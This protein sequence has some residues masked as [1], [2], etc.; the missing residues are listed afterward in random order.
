MSTST[1]HTKPGMTGESITQLHQR[2]VLLGFE[3][4]ADELEEDRYGPGTEAAVRQFQ[5][6]NGLATVDGRVDAATARGLGL[7]ACPTSIEGIVSRPDGTPLSDVAVRLYQPSA[8]GEKVLAQ[9]RSGIDGKFAMPWP[10]GIRGGLNVRADGSAERSVSWKTTLASDA[11]WVRLSVGG[12]YRGPTRFAVLTQML[13]PAA[14]AGEVHLL[15]GSGRA[16]DLAAIGEAV[17]VPAP[18]VSR[19]VLSHKLAARTDLDPRVCFALLAHSVT[20]EAL[21]S[22]ARSTGD[23]EALDD[24]YV[25][26]L[27]DVVLWQHRDELRAGLAAAVSQNLVEDVDVEAA[28]AQL[29]ELRI[30]HL[31][32]KPLTWSAPRITS[33]EHTCCEVAD[34][35]VQASEASEATAG[36]LHASRPLH[37]HDAPLGDV[38]AAAL[39]EPAAR[40]QALEAFAAHGNHARLDAV[41]DSAAGLT[42]AQR[43]DLRFTLEVAALLG[44]HL[45]LVKHAQQLRAGK[46]IAG[47]ADLAR[48]DEADWA[49]ALRETDPDAAHIALAAPAGLARD[50]GDHSER[51]DHLA[52]TLARRLESRYP[53]VALAGRLAKDPTALPLARTE[54]V[55]AFL[56]GAPAFCVRHTH[57]D[58]FVHDHAGEALAA[59]DDHA[60]VVADLKTLQ[61]AYKLTTRFDHAQ[62]MLAA[63][64]HSAYSIH[65]IGPEQFA[66]QLTAAGATADEAHEMFARAEQ[67]HATTLTLMANLHSEFTGATPAAVA[68]AL[69]LAVVQ[70]SLASLPTVQSLFGSADYCAC[71]DCRA[72]HGPAAYFVDVMEFLKSRNTPDNATN[73]RAIVTGRRPDLKFIEL[74]CDNTNGVVPYVDLVCEILEDAVG[75]AP[76]D[77]AMKA[78]QTA[79]TAA[80]LR[81][82]P[83][84]VRDTAYA[85]LLAAKFPITAPFDLSASEVRAFFRQLGVR[86]HELMAAFQVGSSPT[87]TEIA[88]ERYGF[89]PG[90]LNIV[91]TA[92]PANPWTLWNLQ[93]AGNTVPDPRKLDDRSADRTGTNLQIM[94]FVPILLHRSRLSHRELIQI[95]ETR[96]VN[97]NKVLSVV[98]TG[99][100]VGI[101]TDVASCDSGMQMVV[102]WT[103]DLLTRFNRFIR[104]W[105]QLG[106]AIWDLDKV[107]AAPKVANGVLDVAA[108]AQL[109]RL[110]VIAKRLNLPWDELLTLWGPIDSVNYINVLDSD[111]PVVPSVYKRRFRNTTVTQAATVFTDDPSGLTS[112]LDNVDVIAGISAALDLSADDLKRIRAAVASLATVGGTPPPLNVTNLSIIARYVTLARG[113][114]LSIADLLAAIAV[115]GVNPFPTDANQ[116]TPALTLQFLTALDQVGSS[117]FTLLELSYL[118]RHESVVDSKLGLADATITTWLDEIRRAL[119]RLATAPAA[120]RADLVVQQISAM[121]PLDPS[122]TQQVVQATLPGESQT[123][124]ALFT[125]AALTTRNSDGTFTTATTRASFPAIYDAYTALDKMRLLLARWKVNAVDSLWLLQH[126]SAAGWMQLHTLPGHAGVTTPA[127]L[128]TLDTLRQNVVVQQTLASATG[129]RL[130]DFVL[131]PG[132]AGAGTLAAAVANVAQLGGWNQADILALATRFSWT[133][134]G[135]LVAGATVPR[136]RDLMA[137]PRR[138]GADVAT[139]LLFVGAT[140]GVNEARKARQL[141][142]SWFSNDE[143]LGVAGAIQDVLRE[144]KRAALVDYL[145]ANPQAS[146]NQSWSTVEDLYGFFLIDPEMSPVAETT[147]IKQAAASLQLFVQRCFLQLEALNV[148]ADS[149]WK[150]WDWMK[151]FRLWEAN[152]K[153]FLYPENWY[154]PSQRRDMSPY[155][156]AL[157]D[158]LQQNDLT[159]DVAEDALRSYLAKLVD[160]AHLEV[161]GIWEEPVSGSPSILHVVARTRKAPYV[162]SYRRRESSGAWSA[163]EP[164][165]AGAN[166]NHVMPVIWNKRLFML[167]TEFVEKA[168]PGVDDDVRV[169][170]LPT[171][172]SSTISRHPRRYWEITLSWLERRGELWLPK[173][174]SARKQLLNGLAGG[175]LVLK[176]QIAFRV[177]T[178]VRSGSTLSNL[179]VSLY[180]PTGPSSQALGQWILTSSQDEPLVLNVERSTLAAAEDMKYIAALP[181]GTAQIGTRPKFSM[182]SGVPVDMSYHFNAFGGDNP[183]VT[184]PLS[185]QRP[186]AGVPLVTMLSTM[187]MA[188]VISVRYGDNDQFASPFFV[189]DAQRTFFAR[190]ESS[191]WKLQTFYHPFAEVF[192]QR[193]NQGGIPGLFDRTVQVNPDSLRGIVQGFDFASTYAPNADAAI[194]AT[195]YPGETIDYTPSGPYS[196]Y[197][198]ELFLHTPLLIAKRLA[199]NQRFEEAL[200]WFHYIFNPNTVNVPA[201]APPPPPAPPPVGAPPAPGPGTVPQRYWNPKVFRDLT[202]P[203]YTAQRIEQ[204]LALINQHD[205]DL[206]QRVTDWRNN[207]FDPN[208]V[209]A[210]RPVAYQKAVVMAY[211]S[212]LIAWADQLF[213]GD[214]IESINEATQLYLLANQLLGPRPQSLRA[215]QPRQNKSYSDL[216][217]IIDKFSNV[218]VDIEN[219]VSVPP[220]ATGGTPPTPTP[221]HTFYFCI[222]PNDQMLSFWDTVADRL[223]KIRHGMNLEGVARPLALFEPPIDPGLLA[224]AAAAG[225]DIAAAIADAATD[226]GCYRFPALWQ[227]AHDL[228][229][230]VRSLGNAIL[231]ASERQDGEEMAR[232]RATQEVAVTSA[233]REAKSRQ[234]EEARANKAALETAREMAKTREAY[235]RTRPF[236]NEAEGQ[237]MLLNSDALDKETAATTY[238]TLAIVASF[239]PNFSVG[240]AGFGGSPNISASF[241]GDNLGRAAG[242]EAGK[243]RGIAGTQSRIANQASTLATYQR[244]QEDWFFQRDLA[245]K[246]IEQISHQVIAA[247]LR[248]AFAEQDLAAQDLQV[249]D[250]RANAELLQ[251]KFTNKEL[252]SWMLSQLSSTYFH[253]YQLAYDLARRASKAYVFELGVA[254]PGFIQFGYWDSLHRGLVAGD[255]LLLDLRRLQA[256]HL[257]KNKR[258]LELTRHVSLLQLNPQAL[259]RLRETGSCD[260]LLPERLF[261]QDQPGH[262]HRRIKSVSV[263]LPCVTGPYSSVNATLSLVSHAIRNSVSLTGGYAPTSVDANGV[264]T[265]AS[266]FAYVSAAGQAIAL[267]T[268]RED[269]GM[270]EVS[271]RDERYLPFEGAGAI[272][273]WHLEL[274]QQDNQFDIATLSD[275]VLHMRYTARDGG[276]ALRDVARTD[277]T[278]IPPARTRVQLLSARTEFP[279]AY[280]RLFAPT[281]SGQRLDL[282]LG[283]QHLAFIPASQQITLTGV[284]AILAL[285]NDKNYTDYGAVAP[286]Q[287]LKARVGLTPGDGS[288]PT[289]ARPFVPGTATSPLGVVPITDVVTLSAPV[290]PLTIA[291]VEADLAA[292]TTLL[293]QSETQPD[294]TV[295]HRLARDKIDDI[296]IVVT[297]QVAART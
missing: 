163:W 1:L 66:A 136:I 11:I 205:P 165:D 27:L 139:T 133:T 201:A 6:A 71:A 197:N 121:L 145:L 158:D 258:E 68:P 107:L 182:N 188:R 73:A 75:A 237:A 190:F 196:I 110:D 12:P 241:G 226:L 31:A 114:G 4:P 156:E 178:P 268:G 103:D 115:T 148:D 228:C 53:T 260:V 203:D 221:L 28:A 265:E 116:L 67:M 207:P 132:G 131:A 225:I 61:R 218:M 57:I 9:T 193:L 199:D 84:F 278:A 23:A 252:Y 106:C 25:D 181:A 215:I 42:P 33:D 167:W 21:A 198:W 46:R 276:A 93:A 89:A 263:T 177:S 191:A 108:I 143:W 37:V 36:L 5:A 96:F 64:H 74:S 297:Y 80:E 169:P 202:F 213:R 261:D 19:Y 140:V 123:I 287:R 124:A 208:L 97:P 183:N 235:Y 81:A 79:G 141:T 155:F 94:A 13:E 43:G 45:P 144:Q 82:N 24:A 162:Y 217:D 16:P 204:V 63:G 157:V 130:F 14:G 275:V 17:R 211:I 49:A 171:D 54:G 223:F 251:A 105:R 153:I 137:W 55:R 56:D 259:V 59:R 135:Q 296:L 227:V 222:P 127:T 32:T 44:N 65:A 104:L 192:V 69:D 206:E 186:V 150:Q 249:A 172:P 147:R 262:Y 285:T 288:L 138:L 242:A 295:L 3:L 291:F 40:R 219:I 255:K 200:R 175:N 101:L 8:G 154:D 240:I 90:A 118:L 229:Q 230:D 277:A 224:R 98:E 38:V 272:S 126:A 159:N 58:R 289:T 95:L 270:F 247:E 236:M 257:S 91:T 18:D 239:I 210:A 83:V 233:V 48:L 195:P 85:A 41:V 174:Q 168:L 209:A 146:R 184:G 70:T 30:D 109:A 279:D 173:R 92:S 216:S 72:V 39:A 282:A 164:I 7:G 264:P 176:R 254:D 149:V 52:R 125:A 232:L 129:V 160:V 250:A 256:E 50:R 20:P 119:V 78:R 170:V 290:S 113:L 161:S 212:T 152:R 246:E 29:H 60:Q 77:N 283:A 194:V 231:A 243:L 15:G 292:E 62:A 280:A 281:G 253:A 134:P 238:D 86:R 273:L 111:E 234:L 185:L 293:V 214:T 266:R 87:D 26:Q 112:N 286:A 244:R 35:P 180:Q 269:A 248:I 189:S 120:A 47:P 151:R 122:L 179:V 76:T 267:S 100:L 22:L 128:A 284:S 294:S 220:P 51:I 187:T 2:L 88:G 10:P 102:G 245:A 142:K 166:A 99:V 34:A 117:G 271:L 274:Q